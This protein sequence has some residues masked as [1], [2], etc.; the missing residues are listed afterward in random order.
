MFYIYVLF[1]TYI[2]IYIHIYIYEYDVYIYIYIYICF[3]HTIY[4]HVTSISFIY[5]YVC[6]GDLLQRTDGGSHMVIYDMGST[7][8]W[9]FAIMCY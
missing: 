4:T 1:I 8:V 9:S 2:Y 3:I 7:T 5:A 6:T